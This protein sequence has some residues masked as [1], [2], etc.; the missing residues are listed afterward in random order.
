MKIPPSLTPCT[1]PGLSSSKNVTAS[2]WGTGNLVAFGCGQIVVVVNVPT[3]EVVQVLEGVH[4][5]GC[6]SSVRWS[7]ARS[8]IDVLQDDPLHHRHL[9]ASGDSS[10]NI[11]VWDVATAEA[12]SSKHSEQSDALLALLA[13]QRELGTL[14]PKEWVNSQ[15]SRT[16]NEYDSRD[17]AVISALGKV[18]PVKRDAVLMRL[19]KEREGK[20]GV[21]S[22][23]TSSPLRTRTKKRAAEISKA[24]EKV[25]LCE[26]TLRKCKTT[27]IG[28]VEKL[29]WH[30]SACDILICVHSKH[31]NSFTE[32]DRNEKDSSSTLDSLSLHRKVSNKHSSLVL[33]NWKN[34]TVIWRRNFE[35]S[36]FTITLN[37]FDRFG[38]NKNAWCI[39]S[40]EG[41]L[42]FATNI[43]TSSP[44]IERC[45]ERLVC[46]SKQNHFNLLVDVKWSKTSRSLLFC[47]FEHKIF[48]F[49]TEIDAVL[50]EISG[51]SHTVS[52]WRST[53]QY[54][55]PFVAIFPCSQRRGALM[56][57]HKD[58]T[59]S[60]WE[61]IRDREKK[62]RASL[63]PKSLVSCTNRTGMKN[64]EAS[65]LQSVTAL[66]QP[67]EDLTIFGISDE[68][69]T[70]LWRYFPSTQS[71]WFENSIDCA[72][73]HFSEQ[74][75][76]KSNRRE[77]SGKIETLAT[78]KGITGIPSCAAS[79]I[80]YGKQRHMKYKQ[81][82]VAIGTVSGEI[83]LLELKSGN[84]WKRFNII[85]AIE[86][87]R[88]QRKYGEWLSQ[89]WNHF[90]E[91]QSL[92]SNSVKRSSRINA[93]EQA[94]TNGLCITDVHWAD[95]RHEQLLCL[96]MISS[97]K[98][99]SFYS[100]AI[101]L[102][103][104][105]GQVKILQE[106][107]DRKDAIVNATVTPNFHGYIAMLQVHSGVAEFW[108]LRTSEKF[109]LA[110]SARLSMGQTQ[111]VQTS[112]S[113]ARTDS[114]ID[115][116]PL[117]G[118]SQEDNNL[119]RSRSSSPMLHD[120]DF[121]TPNHISHENFSPSK[122]AS[123]RDTV[124]TEENIVA[125]AY[126]FCWHVGSWDQKLNRESS[127]EESFF[128]DERK[129]DLSSD[130]IKVLSMDGSSIILS[131]FQISIRDMKK[132]V[133][134]KNI[135]LRSLEFC[136]KVESIKNKTIKTLR[137]DDIN[138]ERDEEHVR[139]LW[140]LY[141]AKDAPKRLYENDLLDSI[142]VT[143]DEFGAADL[144]KAL[145]ELQVLVARR[146][147]ENAFSMFLA[148][149][150]N[151]EYC[152]CVLKE[153]QGRLAAFASSPPM[154]NSSSKTLKMRVIGD[155]A[156]PAGYGDVAAIAARDEFLIIGTGSGRVAT[157]LLRDD[158]CGARTLTPMASLSENSA[159]HSL[160]RGPSV[161]A[162]VQIS[163]S[164]NS[165]STN[166]VLR[167]SSG[168]FAT[169]CADSGEVIGS[170]LSSQLQGH[171]L[172][173]RAAWI[174]WASESNPFVVM[175]PAQSAEM[176][177]KIIASAHTGEKTLNFNDERYRN[178]VA[179]ALKLASLWNMLKMYDLSQHKLN[180]FANF[181]SRIS[182][183]D[184]SLG[185]SSSPMRSLGV[186]L[187][188]KDGTGSKDK[189][190]THVPSLISG[191]NATALRTN[192]I[193]ELTSSAVLK[194]LPHHFVE[195]LRFCSNDDVSPLARR[196]LVCANFFGDPASARFWQATL[197]SLEARK[198]LDVPVYS[199]P[200]QFDALQ[201]AH[202]VREERLWILKLRQKVVS[203]EQS[204]RNF[205]R[206]GVSEEAVQR[207]VVAAV[208]ADEKSDSSVQKKT[209]DRAYELALIAC[210]LA[211]Q[212]KDR[213]QLSKVAQQLGRQLSQNPERTDVTIDFLCAAGEHAFAAQQLQR[214]KRWRDAL[215]LA[216][217][218]SKHNEKKSE[219][220]LTLESIII[221]DFASAL[222]DEGKLADAA[223]SL[224]S[225][226]T[227]EALQFVL[228]L[229]L[230]A[231]DAALPLASIFVDVLVKANVVRSD[232]QYCQQVFLRAAD[233]FAPM[234]Q[235]LAGFY[236]SKTK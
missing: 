59:V 193:L 36:L 156:L 84:V 5:V 127:I 13:A 160:L 15:S 180:R 182:V 218:S 130:L 138:A 69:R 77:S 98:P 184:L 174:G 94:K 173:H 187:Q 101:L 80:K 38:M 105:T 60:I 56:A 8:G 50:T 190:Q 185:V 162:I 147:D 81:N 93:F 143:E 146:I 49:D 161:G 205:L 163:L 148:K 26:E 233:Y 151:I 66:R 145:L 201:S 88:K 103:L 100:C 150:R 73:S 131:E 24:R 19:K 168:A 42:L 232:N 65:S 178:W 149:N 40:H 132:S 209:S 67:G 126:A 199:L 120:K 7:D 191:P 83:I 222:R 58:G 114:K 91:N 123:M 6:I 228:Q 9:L 155:W 213:Q 108:C 183:C 208:V 39:A 122:T 52:A 44:L 61:D 125:G 34:R 78:H 118:R 220:A 128:S 158:I 11:V 21:F 153:K 111:S 192:L 92:S 71:Q 74:A 116:S 85:R 144:Y 46:N 28:C 3:L 137:L 212:L 41:S 214:A 119:R 107:F 68:G 198:K 62:I 177:A 139:Q 51:M 189:G 54:T 115:F 104:G 176:E 4:H 79:P 95:S 33:W 136:L 134:H 207:A 29:A 206:N 35:D 179:P 235:S 169:Y 181:S 211:S 90:S 32:D 221:N 223:C 188:S 76:D 203:V 10:G 72:L 159:I 37:P 45:A 225:L 22:V 135:L 89:K 18:N 113:L 157:F 109:S 53:P 210:L 167:Y 219:N 129:S 75:K 166:A 20:Q 196:A 141:V 30:P 204:A 164:P 224:L 227:D 140:S 110:M 47:A 14:L 112:L 2:D 17:F 57:W 200:P 171:Q 97:P 16:Q 31:N 197:V 106:C 27:T 154:I 48:L 43:H 63:L 102:H 25:H 202:Y 117:R 23:F 170:S 152:F 86:R 231:A 194:T 1:F 55:S 226:G 215:V 186:T 12:L 142:T 124:C 217:T 229:M 195:A 87:T 99:G 133:H 175:L 216:K 165:T 172:G 96:G 121:S 236:Q 234:T 70:W 230:F 82:C 64:L